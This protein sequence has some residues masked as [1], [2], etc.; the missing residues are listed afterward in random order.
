MKDL[1]QPIVSCYL[2]QDNAL[3][4]AG[5]STQRLLGRGAA[6]FI[7]AGV[8]PMLSL[9]F[10]QASRS[11]WESGCSRGPR[12]LREP[13]VLDDSSQVSSSVVVRVGKFNLHSFGSIW[14]DQ[15]GCI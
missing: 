3:A 2:A 4:S 11:A 9:P 1:A 5:D 8:L 14:F 6:R 15:V 13:L 12:V 10:V 7:Y